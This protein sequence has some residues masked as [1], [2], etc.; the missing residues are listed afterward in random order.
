MNNK[1]K[2]L[3]Y[4]WF[5]LLCT[6]ISTNILCLIHF[7]I[8]QSWAFVLLILIASMTLYVMHRNRSIMYRIVADW[9]NAAI[10]SDLS[11]IHKILHLEHHLRDKHETLIGL[12]Q[13]FLKQGTTDAYDEVRELLVREI[14]RSV[15]IKSYPLDKNAVRIIRHRNQSSLEELYQLLLD[16]QLY[17]EG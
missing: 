17:N 7:V 14:S 4:I 9:A 1:I 8:H 6:L 11:G 16:I 5:G 3:N 13:L 12:S 10:D 2:K 15:I